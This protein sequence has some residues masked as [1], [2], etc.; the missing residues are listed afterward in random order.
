LF[1]KTIILLCEKVLNQSNQMKYQVCINIPETPKNS[2][3]VFERI[4]NSLEELLEELK[5]ENWF[6]DCISIS[7]SKSVFQK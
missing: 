7:I 4:A 6:K 2:L 5:K 3:F 1:R